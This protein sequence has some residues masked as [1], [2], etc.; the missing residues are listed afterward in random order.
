MNKINE[1]FYSIQG[2]GFYSG[3]AAIFVRFSGCNLKC[4]FCDTNHFNF[5]MMCDE[6][7]RF[8]V[9]QYQSNY[10]VLTGGEPSLQVTDNLIALLHESRFYVSIET[11]GTHEFPQSIDWV[12]LSPKEENS[13]IIRRADEVKVVFQGDDVEKWFSFGK[14]VG[15]KHFFLQPCSGQNIS[16]TVSYILD[17]PWWHLSLQTHKLIGIR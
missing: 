5:T 12:T 8:S 7:I 4:S 13:V 6:M 11:N 16:E 17:H 9:M 1:I 10:V 2:E 3:R 15:A 14:A